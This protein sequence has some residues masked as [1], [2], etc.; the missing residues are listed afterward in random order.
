MDDVLNIFRYSINKTAELN[1]HLGR[2]FGLNTDSIPIAG[3][4]MANSHC[5]I[6]L[7][8]LSYYD[9]IWSSKRLPES[10]M[11]E[12]IRA[13][14]GQRVIELTKA[15]FILSLS[16]FE[17]CAKQAIVNFP[18]R[19]DPISGRVY[20]R[21][22]MEFSF[23]KGIISE[24]ERD[25]WYAVIELRNSLIHNNGIAEVD[26]N[27]QLQEN[28]F[29]LMNSGNMINANLRFFP[30]VHLWAIEAFSRWCDAFLTRP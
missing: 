6:A 11:L 18:N 17:F 24:D 4:N 27:F 28:L 22:V 5:T 26:L 10:N 13:E 1:D 8:A 7:E 29:I 3:L 19:L 14:N 23:N 21:K 15:N 30:Q 12:K 16:S 20:M 25:K 9:S 2:K